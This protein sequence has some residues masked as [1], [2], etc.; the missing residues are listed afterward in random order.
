MRTITTSL[1]SL[2]PLILLSGCFPKAPPGCTSL[3][4]RSTGAI[5]VKGLTIP[6]GGADIIKLGEG[7]YTPAARQTI[8]DAILRVNEYR[9]AQCNLL[10]L[11]V[12]LKPQ[13]VDKIAMI[14]EKIA[15]SN[16]L[17]LQ[18]TEDI[19]KNPD[20][21]KV[22]EGVKAKEAELPKGEKG[23]DLTDGDVLSLKT[24]HA[25][26]GELATSLN[27]NSQKIEALV[28]RLPLPGQAPQPFP[29]RFSITGFAVGTSTLTPAMRK[30]IAIQLSR[31]MQAS[32]KAEL[33]Q[34]DVVGY[35]DSSGTYLHNLQLGLARANSVRVLLQSEALGRRSVL[36]TVTSAGSIEGGADARRVE[37]HV[38]PI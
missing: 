1:F 17:I 26:L 4:E 2:I 11:L 29:D 12:S 23:A 8:S 22:V 19:R 24:L 16:E 21:A 38:L 13:P 30:S 25:R 9:L 7:D 31:L 27:E 34:F 33:F 10:S 32:P 37:V 28:N 36:R 5:H 6:V 15:K 14:G 3:V 35:A 18:I 20:T